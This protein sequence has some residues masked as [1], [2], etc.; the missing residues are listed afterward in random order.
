MERSKDILKDKSL[1]HSVKRSMSRDKSRDRNHSR[2]V[3]RR[4]EIVHESMKAPLE[5]IDESDKKDSPN[6]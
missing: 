5:R 1:E 6:E 3:E 4:A 2:S